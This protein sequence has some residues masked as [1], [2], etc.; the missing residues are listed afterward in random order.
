[1]E[2]ERKLF[3]FE[4]KRSFS[5][6]FNTSSFERL[7]L[8]PEY[9]LTCALSSVQCPTGHLEYFC[10]NCMMNNDDDYETNDND[11]KNTI[12]AGGSTAL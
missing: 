3:S 7:F 9:V 10:F 12:R 5:F 1:M 4:L 2:F 11:A 8:E 6:L